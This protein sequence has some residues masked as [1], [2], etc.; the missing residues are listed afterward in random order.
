MIDLLYATMILWPS[1]FGVLGKGL[2]RKSIKPP[3]ANLKWRNRIRSRKRQKLKENQRGI[4]RIEKK[5][6]K[7]RIRYRLRERERENS[8]GVKLMKRNLSRERKF[9]VGGYESMKCMFSRG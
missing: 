6:N 2:Q 3:A 9:Y 7:E 5:E 1:S 4:G 8:S